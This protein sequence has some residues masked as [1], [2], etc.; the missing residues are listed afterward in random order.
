MKKIMGAAMLAG[1]SI[2]GVGAAN[3]EVTAS[4]TLVS[5]YVFRGISQTDGGAAIQGSFDWSSDIFYAGVWASNVNFGATEATELASMELDAYVG[6]TPTTGPISWD[7]SLVGYFY[8]NGDDEIAGGELDYYEGIVGA[9]MNLT[10]QFSIGAQFAYTPD[11]FGETGD[12]TYWE[13]NGGFAINDATSISAAYGVQDIDFA[14]DSYS[15]WNIGI[16]HAMHGFTLG[17][18]YSDTEDAFDNGYALDE[19]SADGRFV[20][21]IGREL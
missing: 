14:P 12:G 5:D 16:E 2:A 19:T 1:A 8:P 15:T 3:A 4:V 13:I 18:M 11:Y 7:L 21:S 9:S 6:I 17:A 20:I 10:E